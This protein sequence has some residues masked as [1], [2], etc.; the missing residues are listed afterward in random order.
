M[1][2]T[3]NAINFILATTKNFNSNVH[4]AIVARV[5][6]CL[7]ADAQTSSILM[8]LYQYIIVLHTGW[9][10]NPLKIMNSSQVLWEELKPHNSKKKKKI[11]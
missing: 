7:P 10:L 6:A 3:A 4:I 5:L 8:C 1:S 11:F 9:Q 2:L